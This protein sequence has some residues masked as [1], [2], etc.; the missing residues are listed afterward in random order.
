MTRV[1]V[2]IDRRNENESIDLALR[3]GISVGFTPRLERLTRHG[4]GR[5]QA[6]VCCRLRP[7]SAESDDRHFE[8]DETRMCNLLGNEL[9]Q[10]P[11]NEEIIR[12][13]ISSVGFWFLRKRS[14]AS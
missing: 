1:N 4:R 8:L 2:P 12:G 6:A 5:T 3:H 9:T 11:R 13:T 10:L 14:P 7:V